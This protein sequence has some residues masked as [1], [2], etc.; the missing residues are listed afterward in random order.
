[1][2]PLLVMRCAWGVRMSANRLLIL[3]DEVA[4]SQA[5]ER[6]ARGCNY[7]VS[8]THDA[9]AF[10][11][12]VNEWQPTH[13]LLDLQMPVVDGVEVLGRLAA[14]GS[15][16]KILI[17][18]GVEGR[19][20]DAA[21]RIGVERGLDVAGTLLKPFRAAELRELLT[22]LASVEEWS[23][24]GALAAAIDDKALFLVYQPKIELESGNV[25]GFEALLRW[26]HPRDGVIFPDK[27]IPLAET[28]GLMDRLTDAVIDI[29][30]KQVAVWGGSG[31]TSL[32]INLS[33]SNLRDLRFAD[34]LG[35]RCAASGVAVDR[36]VLEL[37][38][39]SAMADP[40]GAMEILTRLRLKGARL[41]IDDFGTGYSSLS[42]LARLPFSELKIDKSFVMA[43]DTSPEARA[44]VKSTIEL[45]HS[46]GLLAV[47][48]GI[49]TASALRVLAE[50]GC[51]IVQGYHIGRPL[52]AERL[53]DW[54]TAWE[55]R[56]QIVLGEATQPARLRPSLVS[57]WAKPY[58][59]SDDM[60]VA[61]IQTLT[62][63]INPLWD[64][65]RNSLVG[66]RPADGG[67]EVLMAP[68]QTIVDRF[69]GSQRLLRGRRLMGDGTFRTAQELIQ[70]PSSRFPL[71]FRI[72]DHVAGAIPTEV[73]EQ[74]LRRYGITETQHRAVAL[75]D[76]VGFSKVEPRSQVAQL[77]SLECSINAAQGIL[78]ELGKPVD[79]ARTTTGD[80]FY[81]WNR[82]KGAPADLDSYLLS[83]LV[84]ADNAIARR[85]GRPEMVPELRT[86]FS[87]GPHY[88]YYQVDGLDPKGHDYI[89]GDVTIG[90]ARMASK[91]L[92]GQIL[93]GDFA[94]PIEQEADPANPREFVMTADGA[95]AR[96][97]GVRLQGRAVRGIRCYLT[98]E[99]RG[100][101]QFDVKRFR[102][103]DKHGFD[104]HVFNQKFNIHLGEAAAGASR[105]DALYLGRR[106]VDLSDF[107]ALEAA[108]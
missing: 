47:A 24:A 43:C 95:F 48:E 66:W 108:T 81:A 46:L 20:V 51:D 80:G 86:C 84:L 10:V 77:N 58:D 96:L 104:H 74:V 90:L 23:S 55:T 33:A 85:D 17:A 4:I 44:I 87:V 52:P 102:I 56:R 9:T 68:Y 106:H 93:I 91:C 57:P 35:E 92:P 16:A 38:E 60:R 98:G 19:V 76:I 94:R 21:R 45:A 71:P 41:S 14:S 72:A 83:M 37:T 26:Q 54:L 67:I 5:I 39:T 34:R 53:A 1:M 28:S 79:L 36:L 88:S 50:L 61:L 65:G 8:V 70:A 3:D 15:R 30:L 62:E 6:I 32:A 25:V 18:S 13:I 49:E 42:Q 22:S 40:V 29:G 101:G 73:I 75:F 69:V 12:R 78:H 82:E 11:E 107:D 97:D 103:R 31:D 7:E 89:V 59:G 105:A 63:R 27:F 2:S 100:G 99:E 64:L